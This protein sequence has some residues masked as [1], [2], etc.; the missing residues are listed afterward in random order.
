MFKIWCFAVVVSTILSGCAS[1]ISAWKGRAFAAHQFKPDRLI[2]MTGE[3]RLAF[4]V[5]PESSIT[6]GTR[7]C[8]ESLPDASMAAAGSSSTDASA[9]KAVPLKIGDAYSS[10]LLQTFHR[11]EIA[12]LY[13]QMG[14]QACQAWA[15]GVLT[16]EEYKVHLN[17][18][19][20]TGVDVIQKRA[21]QPVAASVAGG[22]A[23][24]TATAQKP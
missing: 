4:I 23:V 15:Q 5:H 16:N 18:I 12:E 14:W 20:S 17:K 19:I 13:R 21:A 2:S 3:R 1:S 6:K 11:T 9:L 8:A 24:A 7:F 10:T 22:T